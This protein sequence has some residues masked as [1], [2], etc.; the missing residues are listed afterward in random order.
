MD[1]SKFANYDYYLKFLIL[2]DSGVGKSCLLLNFIMDSFEEDSQTTI[3]L[4]SRQR[5]SKIMERLLKFKY[6]IPQV[7]R[8]L[9]PFLNLFTKLLMVLY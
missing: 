9:K 8:G 1:L 7:K 2:G 6:G 4:I 3:G 5:P